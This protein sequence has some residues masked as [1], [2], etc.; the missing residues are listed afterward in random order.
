MAIY[1]RHP[2]KREGMCTNVDDRGRGGGSAINRTSYSCVSEL[3]L[4]SRHPPLRPWMSGSQY[5][6]RFVYFYARCDLD[7]RGCVFQTDDVVQGGGGTKS[8]FVV[9]RLWW[10]TPKGHTHFANNALILLSV[11][12]KS[13]NS[14]QAS[15]SMVWFLNTCY[16]EFVFESRH[17]PP[18]PYTDE[19]L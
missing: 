4:E 19:M 18:P 9:G 3:V 6:L 2:V 13:A 7:V 10:M 1:Q 5:I 8:N 16:S 15:I 14:Q 17:P 11:I 12:L